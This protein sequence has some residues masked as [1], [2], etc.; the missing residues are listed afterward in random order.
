MAVC[1][2]CGEE[3]P[4]RF[5][6]CGFCGTPLAAVLPQHEVRKTV[7]IVFSDLKGSTAMAERLDSE[8]V[9]EVMSRYFDEMRDALERHGGKIEKYIGD[10]IMAVFGLPRVHEDDALRAVRAAVDMRERLAVLN[11]ELDE[12]WGITIGNRT[13]VN[14]GEVVAGDPTTDQRL[15]TGDTVNTAAR[16]EQA[17]PSCEVLIGEPTYRLVRDAVEVEPVEPLELKGK[18]ERV[19]AYRLVSVRATDGVER[20]HDSPLVGRERE[21]GVLAEELEKAIADRSCRLVTIFAQAGVGKSRLIEEFARAASPRASVHKGRCLPYGRGITFWPL[22]E[23]IRDAAS[24][25][26]DDTP[27]VALDKLTDIAGPGGED[28]VA[29]VASAVGLGEKDFPLD[30]VFWGTRKLFELQ[31]T[32]QPLVVVFEDIHW[33]ESAFLDLIEHVARTATGAPIL[34]VCAARP[35]LLDRRPEWNERDAPL[36]ELEPLSAAESERI[37][38]HL[39]GDAPF[40]TEVRNRIIAAAE[41]NPLFVQQVLSMMIDDGLL[42]QED[43]GWIPVGD[44]SDLA[45]P[46]TIQAL[47]AARLDLLSAEERAV[48]E[49]ASVIGLFFE[50]PPVEELVP[51]VIHGQVEAHLRSM[52]HKQLV[53]PQPIETDYDYRFHH[54]LVRDAAYQGI[55][56]RARAT[57]HERFADWAEGVNRDRGRE[58]QF[59]EILGYHLEQ[60]YQYLS[61]LGPLDAHGLELGARAAARLANAGRRAFARGDMTA[62]ANLLRRG[63]SLLPDQDPA[64]LELLPDLGEAMMEIGEFAWA[65]VYL[66]EALDGAMAIGD[67]RLRADALLTRLLVRH[68]ATENLDEWRAEVARETEALI[69]ILEEREAH[70]EL[71][72]AW[73]MVAFVHGIACAWEATAAAQQRAIGYAQAAGIRRQEARMSG[74]YS[75]ALCAGP[76]PVPEAIAR[77]SE[78]LARGLDHR[79]S[80]TLVL[81][82]LSL[83]HAMQGDFDR[84]RELYRISRPMLEDYGAVVLAASTCITSGRVELLA[85][86][87]DAA[88]SELRRDY[89]TLVGLGELYY[90]PY[91]AVL[92]AQTL[93]A[94]GKLDEAEDL[95]RTGAEI[96]A[97]DDIESQA[98]LRSVT[99]KILARRGDVGEGVRLA[100]EATA[101]L[102]KTDD[103]LARTEALVDLAEV[104]RAAGDEDDALIALDEALELCRDKQMTIQT[105]RVEDLLDPLRPR[106]VPQRA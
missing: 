39:L 85:G 100:R 12:R 52:T 65:Q 49:P 43:G 36:L 83:L 42:R 26:D 84:A 1:S 45:I 69:P 13:G 19:P 33:A 58:M 31:A 77:C 66:E 56:K 82:S 74:A 94:Q 6:L 44:L 4:E 46:G 48:L 27:K 15:V 9:R 38:E 40:P 106:S 72:K 18:S 25:R 54:I 86:D 53:R 73:R 92:L 93:Y 89:D 87:L 63:T 103:I 35:D 57:M 47:L 29:R 78:I 22:V 70:A 68:H 90:R 71:A 101:L 14:T 8:A 5:R 32:R 11:R 2:N 60:A 59:E 105:E 61:E 28:A 102:A 17:A 50:Q 99:A 41:G 91:V 55:L 80:E 21:L 95:A 7:T 98:V 81:C 67:E 75:M 34:L 97:E 23:I 64:R 3:N 76:T 79:Q 62:A 30:E 104:L 16:L 10:A 51:D 88:E 20:R 24:I 37:V 96:A